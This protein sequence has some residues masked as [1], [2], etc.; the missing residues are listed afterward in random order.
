MYENNS[1]VHCTYIPEV[2][3]DNSPEILVVGVDSVKLYMRCINDVPTLQMTG[4]S[5]RTEGVGGARGKGDGL[6]WGAR[7]SEYT[8]HTH[9]LT[10]T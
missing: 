5:G 7:A 9:L 3:D 6:P 4:T 8:P 10:N 2:P 1:R